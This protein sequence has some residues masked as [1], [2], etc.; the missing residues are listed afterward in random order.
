[1]EAAEVKII[2]RVDANRDILSATSVVLA[3]QGPSES[4]PRNLAMT[5][6]PLQPTTAT[7]ETLST[8]FPE[9]G[10][11]FIQL[12]ASF[13]DGKQLKSPLK[14]LLIGQEITALC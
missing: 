11:F 6:D 8:D 3:V 9:G 10:N 14:L 7:R 1:M 13:A 2:L 12:L 5:P 4:T